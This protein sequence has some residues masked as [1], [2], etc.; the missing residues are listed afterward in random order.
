M[1]EVHKISSFIAHIKKNICEIDY[2]G[3]AEININDNIVPVS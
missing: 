2:K 1:N 3:F